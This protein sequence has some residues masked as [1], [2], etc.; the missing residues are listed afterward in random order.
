MLGRDAP[1]QEHGHTTRV[2]PYSKVAFLRGLMSVATLSNQSI[3][4][5]RGSQRVGNG[6]LGRRTT[7]CLT[8]GPAGE[9]WRATVRSPGSGGSFP[10][11]VMLGAAKFLTFCNRSPTELLWVWPYVRL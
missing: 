2:K 9:E 7:L 3:S 4:I 1:G 8:L 10:R 11:P 5:T 6:L